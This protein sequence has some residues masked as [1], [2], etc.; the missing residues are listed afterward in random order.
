MQR[1]EQEQRPVPTAELARALWEGEQVV[2]AAL[3]PLGA[4]AEVATPSPGRWLRPPRWRGARE[5]I[6]HEVRAFA[7]KCPARFGVMKGEL[8]SGL[9]SAMDAALFD[10]AFEALIAERLL[11]LR[12][13]R[14][15]PA[16]EPWQ[17]P[18]E[19]VAAL[20]RIEAELEAGGLAVPESAAWQAKLGAASAEVVALGM[21]LERLVRVSGEFTYTARQLEDL[22]AKLAAHFARRPALSVAEFKDLSGV[23]RK[24]AVP[25]MEHCDR[26]GWTARVGDERR[27]GGRLGKG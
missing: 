12:G 21:L 22:R 16:G 25:L 5:A 27:A 26:V 3:E 15:R 13:E 18:A 11:E 23:S 14:V 20:E 17:P 10:A 2:A 1:L 19:T 9:K 7:T 4:R 6:E 24:Y 8:K